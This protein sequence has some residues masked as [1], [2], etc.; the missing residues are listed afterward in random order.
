MRSTPDEVKMVLVDPKKVEFNVYEGIPHLLMPVVTDPKK[1]SAAL[2]RIVVEMDERYETFKNSETKN[3][4]T[5]NEYV[6][7][8]LKKNP[9]C[10]SRFFII[11]TPFIPLSNNL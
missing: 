4:Q 7:K 10:G 5:Y 1:A 2:Q 3:I 11:L 9:D 6:E 8:Q